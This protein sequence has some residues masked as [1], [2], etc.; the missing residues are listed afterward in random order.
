[1]SLFSGPTQVQDSLLIVGGTG[2]VG[3]SV[4]GFLGDPS[5]RHRWSQVTVTGRRRPV[6]LPRFVRFVEW[7]ILKRAP[8]DLG[9]FSSVIHAAT[10]ASASLIREN[11]S[12]VFSTCVT[13]T[14]NVIE[15]IKRFPSPPRLLFTSS[16]A[17]YGSSHD[18]EQPIS[19]NCPLGP[20]LS[21][22]SV[23][24]AEGKRAAEVL[25]HLASVQ[26]GISTVICRLFA[27]SGKYLPLDRH[28]AIGNFVRQAVQEHKI[29]IQGNP[30]TVRSYLDQ[31]DLA[32]WLLVALNSA[33][34]GSVFNVGSQDAITIGQLAHLVAKT[35]TEITK[36]RVHVTM[37]VQYSEKPT[38]YVPNTSKIREQLGALINVP[39]ERSVETMVSS[40]LRG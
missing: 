21:D 10:P 36:E 37:N 35:T 25:V 14:E 40:L 26:F 18:A 38:F 19:E 22:W 13:G 15:L 32:D 34:N 28:F 3:R 33:P 7:D 27:F 11:P 1:M 30:A 6:W 39:L 29:E 8:E 12:L 9:P 5:V 16:G 17:V 2:F 4:I 24:Y 31:E 23:S 20:N